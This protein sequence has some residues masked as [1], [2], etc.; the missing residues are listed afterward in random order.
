MG[1]IKPNTI[2]YLSGGRNEAKEHQDICQTGVI[3]IK[4]HQ[5]ICKMDRIELNSIKICQTGRTK[6]T[7][8][9]IS[10]G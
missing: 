6:L 8:I 5:N 9:N 7:D 1:I 3:K 10:V 2:S 4:W